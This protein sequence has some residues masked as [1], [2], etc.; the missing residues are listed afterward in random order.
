MDWELEFL[1][2]ESFKTLDKDYNGIPPSLQ[3]IILA[4][5]TLI[6]LKLKNYPPP[7]IIL[8]INGNIKFE[9]YYDLFSFFLDIE[10]NNLN[11]KIQLT[12]LFDG[13]VLLD[14]NI[15]NCVI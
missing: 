12:V 13:Q 2:L 8:G 1:K 5:N 9:W 6:S 3:S 4:T 15:I 7:I 14:K 11:S 10:A